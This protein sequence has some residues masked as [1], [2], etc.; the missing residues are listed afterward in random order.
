M[1]LRYGSDGKEPACYAGNTDLTPGSGRSPG[2]GNTCPLQCSC[3]EN[4]VNR[5]AQQATVHGVSKSQT[6]LGD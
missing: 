3:L 5:V 2:E 6:P 4:C 1:M